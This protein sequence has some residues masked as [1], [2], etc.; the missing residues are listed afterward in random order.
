M[1]INPGELN[2]K[3][4]IALI[5]TIKDG[6][7]F[8]SY[9]IEVV[10][11]SAWA[12]FTRTSGTETVKANA[13]FGEIKARFLVR[14]TPLEITRKMFVRYNGKKYEIV[15]VNDYEDKNEYIEIWCNIMS[16]E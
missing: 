12:K 14:Y 16:I 2:K 11:R 1:N 5:E 8:G 10:K 13:D 4:V 7:G 15:Y 9:E 6:D 3:I